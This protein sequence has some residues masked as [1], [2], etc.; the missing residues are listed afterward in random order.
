METGSRFRGAGFPRS[1]LLELLLRL[2]LKIG[3]E[4]NVSGASAQML[5]DLKPTLA[6][7]PNAERSCDVLA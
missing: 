7:V 3:H 6:T 2:W 4:Q 1:V 5:G